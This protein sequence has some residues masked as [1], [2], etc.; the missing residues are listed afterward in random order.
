MFCVT[1]A[2]GISWQHLNHSNLLV[3][4]VYRFHLYFHVRLI[5]N[6]LDVSLPH[7][8]GFSKVKNAYIKSD[9]YSVCDNYSVNPDK[10]WIHGDRLYTMDYGIFG[11]EVKATGRSPPDNLTWWIITQFKDFKR[12][13]IEKISISMRAYV[14]LVITSQVKAISSV[15]GNSA[16]AVDAQQVFKSTFKALINEDYSIGVNIDRYQGVSK[17]ALSKVDFSVGTCIYMLPSDLNLSMGKTKGCNNKILVNNTDMNTGSNMDINKDHKKMPVIPLDD[18]VLQIV[19][20]TAQHDNPK[21]FT[22]KHN[23]EKLVITLLIVGLD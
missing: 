14:Y 9:H 12:K 1:S 23:D 4:S 6:D 16:S 22:E 18:D 17:H 3:H 20:P 15:V 13:G 21:I 7:E 2:L 11:Y 8:D 19:V 5:L 10:T